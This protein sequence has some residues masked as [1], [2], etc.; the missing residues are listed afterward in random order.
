LLTGTLSLG[1]RAEPDGR[2]SLVRMELDPPSAFPR[3][4]ARFGRTS[5]TKGAALLMR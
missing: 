3:P 2:I 5:E 4:K 1:N